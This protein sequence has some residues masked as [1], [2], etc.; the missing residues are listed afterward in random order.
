MSSYFSQGEEQLLQKAA[1][2]AVFRQALLDDP[3][4]TIRRQ[5]DFAV[6]EGFTVQFIEK[7]EG[8]DAVIVLPELIAE[9]ANLAEHDLE[10]VA[11][12]C[13]ALSRC[14]TSCSDGGTFEGS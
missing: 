2:D 4:G 1:T 3:A 13:L 8:V 9:P 7:P 14:G 12:G 10:V 5:T 11:G 6:P